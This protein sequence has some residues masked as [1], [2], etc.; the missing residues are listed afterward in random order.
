MRT[1]RIQLSQH[2]VTN[3]LILQAQA[4]SIESCANSFCETCFQCTYPRSL[5]NLRCILVVR[6]TSCLTKVCYRFTSTQEAETGCWGVMTQNRIHA[7]NI[8]PQCVRQA[9]AELCELFPL[10]QSAYHWRCHHTTEI[11]DISV[12]TYTSRTID[13]G[14]MTALV[15]IDL[16]FWAQPS[17]PSML[18]DIIGLHWRRYRCFGSSLTSQ[19]ASEILFSALRSVEFY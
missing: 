2:Q 3:L 14:E 7:S 8:E 13:H 12:L 17:I 5:W 18:N 1:R 9:L 6:K 19:T 11:A 16:R 15:L 10:N 4:V